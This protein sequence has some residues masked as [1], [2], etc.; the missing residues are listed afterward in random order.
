[1]YLAGNKKR[2]LILVL[3]SRFRVNQK[4]LYGIVEEDRILALE[5]S[6]FE[7]IKRS[8]EVFRIDQIQL[9]A[10]CEP[11]KVVCVGLNYA[12]HAQE[13]NLELP[14]VPILFMK[15]SSTVIGPMEPI[16]YPPMSQQVDYEAELAVIIGKV[17][18]RVSVMEVRD[19][20]FGYTCGNDVTARDLQRQDGQWTRAKSFDS[21]CPLGPW[22]RDDFDP[23]EAEIKLW[24]N[25]EIKQNSNTRQMVFAIDYLISFISQIMT[26][27]PGDVILTGTPFGVGP[28]K[29]GDIISIE[30]QGLGRLTNQ[31]KNGGF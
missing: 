9:L 3:F 17:T 6:P 13:L 21:F 4:N 5:G 28:V 25:D 19:H 26:L 15:P 18:K 7:E 30:I 2:R 27:L 16:I 20:V 31:V 24:V 29:P 14:Q 11:S 12:D 22:I 8:G 10:P 1:M 23:R